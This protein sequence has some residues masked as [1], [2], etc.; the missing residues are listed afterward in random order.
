M[1][2]IGIIGGL[3]PESTAVYYK[4]LNEGVRER[5][6]RQHQAKIV[7]VSVD[8]GEIWALRQKGVGAWF[9]VGYMLGLNLPRPGVITD[10]VSEAHPVQVLEVSISGAELG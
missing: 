9:L 1:K 10:E 8:G 2:V 3:S 5:T 6:G 4:A 7:L